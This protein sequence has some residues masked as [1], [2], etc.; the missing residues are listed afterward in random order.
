MTVHM[1]M[2]VL[3]VPSKDDPSMLTNQWCGHVREGA[4]YIRKTTK[5]PYF[6]VSDEV[7]LEMIKSV[8]DKFLTDSAI[9]RQLHDADT[10]LVESH[11]NTQVSMVPHGKRTFSGHA[12]I[13]SAC[14]QNAA[15]RTNEGF[16]F[17][18]LIMKVMKLPVPFSSLEYAR[19]M[20]LKTLQRTLAKRSRVAKGHSKKRKQHINKSK[21]MS[22]L[23]Q[24]SYNSQID[25]D[26]DIDSDSSDR[27]DIDS[28][29]EE[30]DEANAAAELETDSSRINLEEVLVEIEEARFDVTAF[31]DR[32][33][34][35]H[36][37]VRRENGTS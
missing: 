1:G 37:R 19:F 28:E 25:I 6:K 10:N 16:G 27:G 11:H 13:Y 36:E 9:R 3:Q 23:R 15:S 5:W 33:P 30:I 2:Y 24:W 12:G 14:M 20:D 29:Q 7:F 31:R 21:R 4:T 8:E 34:L 26:S 32:F 35:P 18:T 17:A 22:S